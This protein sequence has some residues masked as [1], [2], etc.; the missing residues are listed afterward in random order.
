MKFQIEYLYL[1]IAIGLIGAII[2]VRRLEDDNYKAKSEAEREAIEE[3]KRYRDRLGP[4]LYMIA[5]VFCAVTGPYWIVSKL[6]R[7]L[8]LRGIP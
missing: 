7:K 5:Y 1:W 6:L 4:G 3:L 2:A 8:G